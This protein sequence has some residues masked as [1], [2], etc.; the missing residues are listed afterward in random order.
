M[1]IGKK[2]VVVR[3]WGSGEREGQLEHGTFRAMK[4]V[5]VIL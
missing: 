3:V 2:Q 4:L 5:Y 1:D